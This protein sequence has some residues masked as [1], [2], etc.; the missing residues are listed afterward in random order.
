MKCSVCASEAPQTSRFCPSCGTEFPS[1]STPTLSRDA[2]GPSV[3]I[4][5]RRNP[6][7][8]GTAPS[9]GAPEGARFLP[10]TT[11]AGRYRIV[12]PVGNGGMGEVYRADDLKLGQTVALKFL[13]ESLAHDG[14]A[15]ARFH[16]EVRTARQVSHPN[17]CRVF[18][19]GESDGAPFLSM[20]FVDGEDLASLLR[21]IGRLPHDK[22]LEIAH[23]LCAGLAAAHEHGVLHRDLKPA[24][25]MIDGRGKARLTD[26]GLAGLASEL[27]ADEPSAGTPAYMAP[28]QFAG[29]EV[30][31][32]S[33]LYSL[34]LVLYEM[35]TGRRAFEAAT[36]VELVRLRNQSAPTLPSRIVKDLD[37]LVERVI[38]RCIEKDP[39]KRHTSA[40][41]VSAALPGGDPLAA[42]LAAGETPS[43]EMVAASGSKEG[44]RPAVAWLCLA[45]VIAGVL[46]AAGMNPRTELWGRVPLEKPP[47]VLVEKAREVVK[48]AGYT[49]PPADTAWG[50]VD[51]G[52][53]LRYLRDHDQSPSRLEHLD[54]RAITF[55]YRQSPQPLAALGFPPGAVSPDD[56]SFDISGMVLVS[57][58]ARGRLLDFQA[59][60]PQ[61]E[62]ASGPAAPADWSVLFAAAGLDAG[63]FSPAQPTWTPGTYA[64][65][66]AAWTGSR[67]PEV[68]LRIE[69]AS[70]RGKPVYFELIG[71]WTRPTRTQAF[72]LTPRTTVIFATEMVLLAALLFGGAALAWRNL[73]TGRGDRK[74][75]ARLAAFVFGVLTLGWAL[76]G[77]HVASILEVSLFLLFLMFAVFAA[78]L[79]WTL[80]IA[81]EPFVRRRWPVVLVTWSRLLAGEL[82]DPL[83]GRDILAGCL[84]GAT[85]A[86]VHGAGRLFP[87]WAG[88]APS[89]RGMH[90]GFSLL[91]AGGS[92]TLAAMLA[93]V[94]INLFFALA[95]LFVLFLLRLV[96]RNQWAAGV[97]FV[98]IFAGI[99]SLASTVPLLTL[100][101]ATVNVAITLFLALRFGLVALAAGFL[102]L[103]T[104]TALPLS[105]QASAWYSG[106]GWT[107]LLLLLALAVYAFYT[108]L[109]G[110]P[111]FSGA[112]LDD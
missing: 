91:L 30:T 8:E 94:A 15:L 102:I 34:G 39:S 7:S 17:V 65:A 64:D 83:L 18:D 104:L 38:L 88:F 96:L 80:Y 11:L 53:Y 111:L 62:T 12:A 43:P 106:I 85:A 108:S 52:D 66:R 81:L 112:A 49:E 13:P 20:E 14:A 25:V 51:D 68:S 89:M 46:A 50:F 60:P 103:D 33:D 86:V 31:V 76:A 36:N 70:Y 98:V 2:A 97:A 40:L 56:P 47:E 109:G 28:E 32:Q 21:R 95:Y 59:V 67:Q 63:Q 82:R 71:P 100:P 107:G 42:A 9:S 41:Q 3:K 1:D 101:F 24:N 74:G 84:L 57:F 22:A 87:A 48:K 26:F 29:K 5:R 90:P 77:H 69:A 110:R 23:Q 58:D 73:R 93:L 75:A 44:L 99:E 54:P 72:R 10:G 105:L 4:P 78:A 35:F 61:V 79:L 16:R 55:F 27:R 19:I 92:R 37:P 45:A 6:S